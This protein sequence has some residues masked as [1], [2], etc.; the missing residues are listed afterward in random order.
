MKFNFLNF[1]AALVQTEQQALTIPVV[2]MSPAGGIIAIALI[3]EE[4]AGLF[5]Q[6]LHA[7][8]TAA[9]AASA[10]TPAAA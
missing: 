5:V 9:Q 10:P 1:L 2:A 3:G 6:A 8:N 4:L 7:Q